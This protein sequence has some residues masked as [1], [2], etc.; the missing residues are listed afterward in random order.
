M[1]AWLFRETILVLWVD[2][3]LQGIDVLATCMFV[4]RRW[5]VSRGLPFCQTC[6]IR[7]FY[8]DATKSCVASLVGSTTLVGQH[9]A[10]FSVKLFVD[11]SVTCFLK[12]FVTSSRTCY[13]PYFTNITLTTCVMFAFSVKTNIFS[14]FEGFLRDYYPLVSGGLPIIGGYRNGLSNS[15]F[16]TPVGTSEALML[17]KWPVLALLVLF[18][19][20]KTVGVSS[21]SLATFLGVDGGGSARQPDSKWATSWRIQ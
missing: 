17:P 6:E 5:F 7:G 4:S 3:T 18:G 19:V 13:L 10:S 2:L 15:V 9:F 14:G 12:S 21:G 16:A 8:S 11:G 1:W 20:F